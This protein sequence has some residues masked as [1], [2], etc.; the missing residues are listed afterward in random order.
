MH[1]SVHGAQPQ[2]DGHELQYSLHAGS[3]V[4]LPQFVTQTPPKQ[5]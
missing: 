5:V 3:H 1:A 2:S 4:P